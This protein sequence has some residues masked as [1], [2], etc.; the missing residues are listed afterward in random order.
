VI[1]LGYNTSGFGHTHDVRAVARVIA[2][3]GYAGIE[4]SL[5]AR[6]FHPD[7]ARPGEAE[8][9]GRLF[10]DLGLGVVVGTGA[11]S[12]L[13]DRRHEPSF[14]T[15]D[16]AERERFLAFIERSLRIAP[17][18]GARVVM[19]HSGL[20]PEGV[21]PGVAWERVGQG[22]RRL[23]GVAREEGVVL[24][25][26]FHPGM[27]V[28]TLADWRRL[29]RDVDDPAFRLTLDVGHVACTEE[30]AISDVIRSCG[31]DVVNVHLEDIQGCVHVHLPVGLGDID[32]GDVFRGLEAVGY[33]GLASAEF[34]T[35]DLDVDDA[36]LAGETWGRLVG[37]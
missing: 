26:E 7:T 8:D 29:A 35:D 2:R 10:A 16:D 5:D 27:F 13:S 6:H 22:S 23:A 3:A 25:F 36:V 24:G 31:A 4:L 17:M 12:V 1:R 33:A 21:D 32:F 11:R 28:R 15:D 9:L 20:L 19:L 30:G 18:L 14:L 37:R 34:N